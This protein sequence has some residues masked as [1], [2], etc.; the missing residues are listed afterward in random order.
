MTG[1][2]VCLYGRRACPDARSGRIIDWESQR[3]RPGCRLQAGGYDHPS[4]WEVHLYSKD[5][6][7]ALQIKQNE[8]DDQNV[9]LVC[10]RFL[11]CKY[12]ALT[13]ICGACQ[14]GQHHG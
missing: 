1:E 12:E 11:R 13:G 10:L 7:Y 14:D 4:P 5:L 2:M 8:L 9:V 3:E 6:F